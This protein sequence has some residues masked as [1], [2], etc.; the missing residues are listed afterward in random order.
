MMNGFD[1]FCAGLAFLLG[2]VFLLLGAF[3]LFF[4]AQAQFSLPP[5][6]GGIPALL[7]WGMV[8]SVRLAWGTS[9]APATRTQWDDDNEG[10]TS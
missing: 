6:L 3:G 10:R 9:T 4:G 2:I 7:G 8:K 5:I 1:K